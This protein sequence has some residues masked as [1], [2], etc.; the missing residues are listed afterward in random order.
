[1]TTPLAELDAALRRRSGPL[2]PHRADA[3]VATAVQ[4]PSLHNTQPWL[5]RAR[6]DVLELRADRER[7]LYST[8]PT[9]REL[10]LS[11]GAALFGVRLAVRHLGRMPR[12]QLLPDTSDRD[13]LAE[14]GD[15]GGTAPSE[16][17][18]RLLEAMARR[19][20]HRGRFDGE[21]VS[22]QTVVHLR[23]AAESEGARLVLVDRPGARRAVADIVASAERTQMTHPGVRAELED[24]TPPLGTERLDGIPATAYPQ[25]PAPAGAQELTGRNF[26]AGRERGVPTE[27][28]LPVAAGAPP[29]V[30]VLLTERDGP[31][32]WLVGGQALHRVL[33]TAAM[34]GVQASLHGQATELD[35]LRRL[36][37]DELLVN[38]QPQ[39]LLQFGHAPDR[40]GDGTPPTP[41]RPVSEVLER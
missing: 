34:D 2:F 10:M 7:Q 18:Q 40:G 35:G 24:W 3:V 29:V 27:V 38:E 26:A 32:D 28:S 8:D 12:V 6:G 21:R 11:C 5:F 20:S 16:Y 22:P 17:V 14:I 25:Q 31:T 23:E 36:L 4:A 37:Q 41:R 33:L 1:M 15:G 30:A 19:R 39:M 9:G 13:L